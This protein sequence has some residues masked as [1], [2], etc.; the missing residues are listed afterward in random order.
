MSDPIIVVG[1]V[2]CGVPPDFTSELH[3][4]LKLLQSS[5]ESLN[6]KPK[7]HARTDQR[8]LGIHSFF[9]CIAIFES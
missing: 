9:G 2:G 5:V 3:L 1:K 4:L 6:C 7:R 8:R